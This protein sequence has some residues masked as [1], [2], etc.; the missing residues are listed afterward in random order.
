[1]CDTIYAKCVKNKTNHKKQAVV[2]N[3]N[4]AMSVNLDQYAYECQRVTNIGY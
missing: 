1:M 4:K 2:H 3:S